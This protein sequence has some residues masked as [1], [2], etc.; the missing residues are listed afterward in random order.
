[1]HSASTRF[2]LL[3]SLTFLVTAAPGAHASERSRD[4]AA[5]SAQAAAARNAAQE[6]C[7]GT[8][9]DLSCDSFRLS[10]GIARCDAGEHY[11]ALK[12]PGA[13]D[14]RPLE[15]SGGPIADRLQAGELTGQQV[16]V[17]GD[18]PERGPI[19]VHDVVPVS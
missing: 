10:G 18:C 1:M 13:V 19:R 5:E 15:P 2:A 11:F 17:V 6:A 7:A 16:R 14:L 4:A 9:V 12:M 8:I 3:L